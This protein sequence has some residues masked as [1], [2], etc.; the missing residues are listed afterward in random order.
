MA[1]LLPLGKNLVRTDRP[2]EGAEVLNELLRQSPDEAQA[3]LSLADAYRKLGDPGRE[4]G[5][6]RELAQQKPDYPMIHILIAQ[7]MLHASQSDYAPVLNELA[8]AEIRTPTD[9]DVFYLRGKVFF[10]MKLYDQAAAAF[11]RSIA[12]KPMD[13]SS[14][15]QLGRVYQK[16]GKQQLAREEFERMKYLQTQA[17]TEPE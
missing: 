13:N 10:A 5:S 6:L 16:L 1:L 11:S 17:P 8:Q 3:Y 14:Y 4:V 2:Q 15:Y 12:L 7:A 9:P